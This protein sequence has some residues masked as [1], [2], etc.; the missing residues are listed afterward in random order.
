M[1]ETKTDPKIWATVTIAVSAIACIGTILSALI[2]ALP[3]LVKITTT[4]TAEQLPSSTP[5]LSNTNTPIV[6]STSTYIWT[7][8]PEITLTPTAYF[9]YEKAEDCYRNKDFDCTISYC[10]QSINLKPDYA[11][12]YFKRGDAYDEVGKY[13]LAISDY[14]K[15]IEL[16]FE[17]LSPAYNYRGVTYIRMKKY[18]LAILDFDVSIS[19]NPNAPAYGNRAEAYYYLE[20]SEQAIASASEA[21]KINSSLAKAYLI[22]GVAYRQAGNIEQAIADFKMAISLNNDSE[23]K[24]LAENELRK[25]GVSTP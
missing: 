9:Y 17:P 12:A 20:N 25:M 18:D 22:R 23:T 6:I 8:T 5:Y 24:A 10:T 7:S 21:I 13:E 1:S 4:Q 19:I 16:K 15:A 11:N 2:G 14:T 3:E